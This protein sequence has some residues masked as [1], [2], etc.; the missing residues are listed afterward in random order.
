MAAVVLEAVS[1]VFADGTSAV[2]DMNLEVEDHE[3]LVLVGPSGCGKSTTLRMIAG[4]ESPNQGQI[5]IGN[6]PMNDVAPKDRDVAMV[7]QNYALYPHMDVFRNMA[8]GLEVRHGTGRLRRM[9]WSLIQPSKAA[10]LREQNKAFDRRVRE[11]A[12]NLGIGHLLKRMPAD[13]SGGERQRVALGRAIVRHPS[14]FLFDEPL[15]NLDARLRMEMRRELKILHQRLQATMIYVTHD[16]TE[17]MTLGQRV[18]VM[19]HGRIEQIG[20]PGEL[21]TSPLT[22]FVAGFLGSPPMNFVD[23]EIQTDNERVHFICDGFRSPVDKSRVQRL[24]PYVGR[25]LT[26]GVR[27]EHV[28]IGGEPVESE[29]SFSATV[30]LVESLGD[31]TIVYLSAGEDTSA[32]RLVAKV[33]SDQDL[34]PQTQVTAHLA[35]RTLYLFDPATGENVGLP[36]SV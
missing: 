1:R 4:L 31:A 2:R 12:E 18:A 16:Q 26:L 6:R 23:G 7:F 21:Y 27:P 9:L 25:R 15:S 5:R 24:K 35:A 33:G 28:R 3:F 17:A 8:F 20:P 29:A 11:V 22:R 36:T 10:R 13:L 19:N 14:V 30:E 32:V 34:E